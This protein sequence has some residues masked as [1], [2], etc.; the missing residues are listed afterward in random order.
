MREEVSIPAF[1][2]SMAG[3]RRDEVRIDAER[4]KAE[5]ERFSVRTPQFRR[6]VPS[7]PSQEV[8]RAY[9]QGIRSFLYFVYNNS[10][11]ADA[12]ESYVQFRPLVEAWVRAGEVPASALASFDET[13][14]PTH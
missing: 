4:E 5:A 1:V 3:K 14:R 13:G 8:W 7:G 10:R 6:G 11:P 9:G 12:P 2:A